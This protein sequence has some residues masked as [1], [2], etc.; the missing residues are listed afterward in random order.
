MGRRRLKLTFPADAFL[1]GLEA[2]KSYLDSCDADDGSFS[3]THLTEIID[4]FGSTLVAH[5]KDE[6]PTLLG[7][8]KYGSKLPLLDMT[9][10]ESQKSPM[11]ISATGNH[12][13]G[14]VYFIVHSKLG[15]CHVF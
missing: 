1:P 9:N 13:P 14:D 8:S 12:S 11:H 4:G 2:Y 3:G 6:I 15:S 10:L 7:L 5:L